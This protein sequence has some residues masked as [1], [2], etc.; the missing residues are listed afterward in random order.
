MSRVNI[1]VFMD[2]HSHTNRNS[3]W[4]LDS[5]CGDALAVCTFSSTDDRLSWLNQ[6]GVGFKSR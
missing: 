2:L 4:S 1:A 6:T 5:E 3:S